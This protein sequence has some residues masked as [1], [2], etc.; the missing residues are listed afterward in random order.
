[1][2]QNFRF[3]TTNAKASGNSLATL[4]FFYVIFLGMQGS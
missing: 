3:V 1:L 2:M 4:P